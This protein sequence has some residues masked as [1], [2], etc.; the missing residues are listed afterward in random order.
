[1]KREKYLKRQNVCVGLKKNRSLPPSAIRPPSSAKVRSF[2]LI[3]GTV[4][5]T[6]LEI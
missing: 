1:M 4:V 6:V 5:K 3:G 2:S